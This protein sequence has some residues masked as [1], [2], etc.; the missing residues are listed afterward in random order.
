MYVT[1][2]NGRACNENSVLTEEECKNAI[3]LIQDIVPGAHF[4]SSS[5]WPTRQPGCF[6][7]TNGMYWNSYL[8]GSACSS[9]KSICKQG[10]A[11][12]VLTRFESTE[13]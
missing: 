2:E 8:F 7:H 5:S 3:P 1:P 11:V 13:K 10:K 6:Y 9:C 12:K 4:S